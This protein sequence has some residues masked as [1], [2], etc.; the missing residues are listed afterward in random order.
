MRCSNQLLF[1]D[2]RFYRAQRKV[3]AANGMNFLFIHQNFPGQFRHV[4]RALAENPAHRVVALGDQANLVDRPQAHPAIQTLGYQPHGAGQPQTHHYLRDFEGHVRRGQSVVRSCLQLQQQGFRPDV[5]VAHPGWGEALFLRDVFPQARHV[6]YF[7]YYYHA[8]GGDL[9]FDPE[10]PID[11]DQRLKVRV[12]N[13]TLL[14]ALVAADQGISPT[15]WQKQRH[16]LEFQHKIRTLHEGIDT[17]VVRPNPAATVEAAGQVFRHGDQVITYVARNLEPYRGFHTFMRALPGI[18]A[19]CPEGR[20][21]IVGGDQ[22]SYGQPPR[23]YNSFREQLCAELGDR[24]DLQRVHFL[25]RLSYVDYL[26]VLQVSACHVYLT[27]PFVLSWSMLEAM[28]AGC[29]VVASATAPV[30]EVIED[31]RNGRLFDFFDTEA[32]TEAVTETLDRPQHYLAMRE[33]ARNTLVEGFDLRS[34][35]LPAWTDYLL[36]TGG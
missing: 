18:L 26:R 21:L 20:V 8:D 22:V 2:S 16:P 28:S 11:I 23:E 34:R 14:H 31:R 36:S 30:Q 27:Y 6:Y 7:E 1:Y 29:A 19:R 35:C 5:V 24:L 32:L 12:K 25:G 3:G 13:S 15:L 10:F 33:S 9:G 4:A 17:R